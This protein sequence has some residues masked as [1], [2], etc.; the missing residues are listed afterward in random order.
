MSKALPGAELG[1]N[2][3][4]QRVPSGNY[5]DKSSLVLC[6][7]TES[8]KCFWKHTPSTHQLKVFYQHFT[9]VVSDEGQKVKL[10]T[11]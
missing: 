9:N 3:K 4:W 8:T 7:A 2:V 11:R 1:I 6:W 10:I 5:R